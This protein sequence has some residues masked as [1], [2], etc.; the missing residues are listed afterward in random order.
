MVTAVVS[1]EKAAV[2]GSCGGGTQVCSA[3]AQLC[4]GACRI[5]VPLLGVLPLVAHFLC[6]RYPREGPNAVPTR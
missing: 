2:D 1:S 6:S 3:G 5:W 4:S